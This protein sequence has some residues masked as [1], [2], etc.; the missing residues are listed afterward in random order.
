MMLPDKTPPMAV[1]L[2]YCDTVNSN[3][4]LFLKDKTKKMDFCL[5][6]ARQDFQIFWDFIGAE[7]DRGAALLEFDTSC[8][9]STPTNGKEKKLPLLIRILRKVAP[10]K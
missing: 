3:I 9:V 4:E 10:K 1:S 7:G 5:E 8:N 6:N 2:D